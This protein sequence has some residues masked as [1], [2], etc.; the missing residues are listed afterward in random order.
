MIIDA[1]EA[2]NSI[3]TKI[4]HGDVQNSIALQNDIENVEKH[5]KTKK[6]WRSQKSNLLQKDVSAAPEKQDA[7]AS[8]VA[9]MAVAM[10]WAVAFSHREDFA[11]PRLQ[12]HR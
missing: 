5:R 11:E 9:A 3:D 10:A 4:Q 1:S 12:G 2:N 8:C 7:A 6:P